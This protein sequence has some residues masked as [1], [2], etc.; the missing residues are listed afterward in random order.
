V[1][2]DRIRDNGVVG[3]GG[4]GFPTHAK[5]ANRVGTVILNGAECEPLLHKDKVLLESRMDRV[6]EGLS[7]AMVL[8]GA[9]EGVVALKAKHE[10]LVERLRVKAG[11]RFRVQ[12]VGDFYPAGDE[13]TLVYLVTGRALGP[14]ELPLAA[15]CLVHNVETLFNL[16]EG[17]PV[18]EKWLTVAGAV[19]KPATVRVPVG[20]AVRDVLSRFTL[21]ARRPVVRTGGLMMGVLEKDPDAV[22]TK[23]TGGIIVLPED[24]PAVLQ[25]ERYSTEKAT[26]AT[27]K[28]SCDQCSF[29]TELCPRYLLGHPVRPE[30]AMRNRMFGRE[31]SAFPGNAYCCECGL[32]TVVACPE[33]VDRMWVVLF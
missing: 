25:M 3:C 4:A 20:I 11:S 6:F 2:L 17:V 28:S 31:G 16:A 13:V 23:T 19:E 10:T 7:A 21:T 5:L 15:D 14:G 32:C 12:A 22:V 1:T 30:L 26:V 18:T 33:G 29:C 24:H 8:T 27:A 9:A